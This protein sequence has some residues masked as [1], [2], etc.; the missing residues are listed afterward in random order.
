MVSSSS[1]PATDGAGRALTLFHYADTGKRRRLN[2]TC[3]LF[4]KMRNSQVD[5]LASALCPDHRSGRTVAFPTLFKKLRSFITVCPTAQRCR[6]IGSYCCYVGITSTA[7]T[8]LLWVTFKHP[9][10]YHLSRLYYS[11]VTQHKHSLPSP[12]VFTSNG[13]PHPATCL[14][15]PGLEHVCREC[16]TEH[17]WEAVVESLLVW[18]A[19]EPG[20]LRP[21]V[22]PPYVQ[23][24]R[25]AFVA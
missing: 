10:G 2:K 22:L 14:A 4:F 11:L 8:A 5:M 7:H 6:Y 13:G 19:A 9:P 12:F 25:G 20:Q 3:E 17:M 18:L 1:W 24:R 21:N 23:S 15:H 16:G